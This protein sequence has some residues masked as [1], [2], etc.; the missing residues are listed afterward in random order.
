MI[1]VVVGVEG[2]LVVKVLAVDFDDDGTSVAR[3]GWTGWMGGLSGA[4]KVWLAKV[5]YFV[6]EMVRMR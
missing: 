6:V 2:L 4:L 3:V 5:M 1:G